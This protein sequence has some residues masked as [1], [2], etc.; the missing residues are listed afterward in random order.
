MAQWF[1]FYIS[2]V[3]KSDVVRT[4]FRL[5]FIYYLVKYCSLG[6]FLYGDKFTPLVLLL[7]DRL[8]R[9]WRSR[10]K[11]VMDEKK[12]IHRLLPAVEL[13]WDTRLQRRIS[14]QRIFQVGIFD[15]Q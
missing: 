4:D 5:T 6:W 8:L 7:R 14:Q 2:L 13:C 3:R 11:K 15:S 12:E 1:H 10:G 9:I